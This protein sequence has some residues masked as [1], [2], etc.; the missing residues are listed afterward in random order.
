MD[1]LLLLAEVLVGD[2]VSKFQLA[3][4]LSKMRVDRKDGLVNDCIGFPCPADYRMN[5]MKYKSVLLVH[6]DEQKNRYMY[7]FTQATA[8]INITYPARL[9]AIISSSSFLAVA[10]PVS[11]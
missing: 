7:L 10:E 2:L 4:L 1:R 8:V 9:L 5:E 3:L 6:I 11:R